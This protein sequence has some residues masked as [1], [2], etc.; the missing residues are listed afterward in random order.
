MYNITS[1]NILRDILYLVY[2]TQ[3]VIYNGT[4]YV[5]GQT[6]RGVSSITAFTFSGTGTQLVYEVMELKGANIIFDENTLDNP[7]SSDITKLSD[8]AIEYQQNTNDITFNDITTLKGFAI[9]LLDFPFYSFEV[10]ETRI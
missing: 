4:T 6:F 2:G 3:S 10:T 7:I 5:A 8:F 1:G 9:E